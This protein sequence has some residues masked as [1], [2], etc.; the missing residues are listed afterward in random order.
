MSANAETVLSTMFAEYKRR[1]ACGIPYSE[2]V[3]FRSDW[4]GLAD[5]WDELI[6]ADQVEWLGKGVVALRQ[7][8]ILQLEDVCRKDAENESKE[9]FN[10]KLNIFN[11]LVPFI[12][13]VLGLLVE[14]HAGIIDW[15]RSLL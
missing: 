11:A 13:F 12:L 6:D 14:H 5:V 2:A 1:I 10:R 4:C 7:A 8:T 9:T 3:Q 15:L